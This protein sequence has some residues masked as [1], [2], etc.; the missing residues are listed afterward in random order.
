MIK[1]LSNTLYIPVTKY[2]NYT[3]H[4]MKEKYMD[5]GYLHIFYFDTSDL[6]EEKAGDG[7]CI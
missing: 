5:Y 2:K 1:I 4:Y 3:L 7:T 6:A